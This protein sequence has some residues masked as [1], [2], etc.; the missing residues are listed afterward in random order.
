MDLLDK[1]YKEIKNAPQE[2][3]NFWN[4]VSS[5]GGKYLWFTFILHILIKGEINT[6]DL[7]F[8]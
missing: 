3:I 1:S 7:N 5:D 2:T 8:F 4:E 6:T